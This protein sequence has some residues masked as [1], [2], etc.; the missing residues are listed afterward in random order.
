M[1]ET[2]KSAL[3]VGKPVEAIQDEQTV[4]DHHEPGLEGKPI[5]ENPL[6][7]LPT[8][9]QKDERRSKD[10]DK[11]IGAHASN[12]QTRNEPSSSSKRPNEEP[13]SHL[14][15][16][17]DDASEE[18]GPLR[19]RSTLRGRRRKTWALPTPTPVVDLEGF[20][21]PVCDGFWKNMWVACA[22]HN[23]SV[24]RSRVVLC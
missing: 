6:L 15:S 21:D 20:E 12:V 14:Q 19:G 23:V 3:D 2:R 7:L 17:I 1:S 5:V 4:S 8:E 16:G 11:P 18:K 24:D 10:D 22:V 9:D 13:S